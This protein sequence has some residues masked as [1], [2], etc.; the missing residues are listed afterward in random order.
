MTSRAPDWLQVPPE[1]G[2]DGHI[3][4]GAPAW[5]TVDRV[6][7]LKVV[8]FLCC[9]GVALLLSMA[10]GL[11][12]VIALI[13]VVGLSVAGYLAPNMYL[14][15]LGYDRAEKLQRA[16]PGPEGVRGKLQRQ[17]HRAAQARRARLQLGRVAL[18]RIARG[19]GVPAEADVAFAF[20]GRQRLWQVEEPVPS[21]RWWWKRPKRED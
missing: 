15:Q 18:N 1:G 10:M 4:I 12:L 14:F 11:S 13:F 9:L 17:L 20:E 8:G 6:N 7:G 21:R 3:L 16:L 2:A 5:F 19:P